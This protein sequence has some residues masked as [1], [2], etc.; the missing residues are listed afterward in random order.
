MRIRLR[1]P[2]SIFAS[3]SLLPLLF[4]MGSICLATVGTVALR[5]TRDLHPKG[6]AHDEPNYAC[7]H[8]GLDI[9][10]L[11]VLVVIPAV[12]YSASWNVSIGP[13]AGWLCLALPVALI[14]LVTVNRSKNRQAAEAS[15]DLKFEGDLQGEIASSRA[16]QLPSTWTAPKLPSSVVA[17][18]WTDRFINRSTETQRHESM[19]RMMTRGYVREAPYVV[20]VALLSLRDAGL[21]RM[22]VEPRGMVFNSFHRVS[23]ERTDLALSRFDLGA[24]ESG[25]L[26]A[27]LDLA[28]R[29]F[30]KTTQP[31]VY[32]VVK[33]WIHQTQDHPFQWVVGVAV[34]QGRDLGLYEPVIKKRAW[35]GKMVDDK[36][37]YSLEH[38]AACDDQAVACAARWQDF[39][40]SDSELQQ[41]LLSEVAFGIQGRQSSSG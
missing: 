21:I 33:E 1:D 8:A 24:V 4:A 31:A 36:P 23:M 20:A 16:N 11:V 17:S 5:G 14:V 9:G 19:L 37:V 3:G 26:L 29:R 34:Q 27:C 28:H 30:R 41:T 32:S 25:L 12:T 35:Y 22:S 7:G 10:W 40:A 13:W 15:S 18:I 38:L 6:A 2:K 39:A